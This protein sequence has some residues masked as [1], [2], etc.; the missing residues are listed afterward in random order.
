MAGVL[1]IRRPSDYN[2]ITMAHLGPTQ[3]S[4]AVNAGL[5]GLSGLAAGGGA[6]QALPSTADQ[7]VCVLIVISERC[8]APE[9][10]ILAVCTTSVL[11]FGF[12]QGAQ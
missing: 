3:P 6:S 9:K 2:S 4:A 1:Q 12:E 11:L 7:Q 8:P 10:F 5:I